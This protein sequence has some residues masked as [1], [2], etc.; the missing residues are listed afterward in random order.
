MVRRLISLQFYVKLFCP[1]FDQ[2]V[3]IDIRRQTL[4]ASH[5]IYIQHTRHMHNLDMSLSFLFS[6]G[7]S[8][9]KCIMFLHPSV[10]MCLYIGYF[11]HFGI[12]CVCQCIMCSVCVC[13]LSRFF[14]SQSLAPGLQGSTGDCE[15]LRGISVDQNRSVGIIWDHWPSL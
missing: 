1:E 2:S 4:I 12:L 13:L 15:G 6:L 8:C 11:G 10:G 5:N 3:R 9:L 7:P 14:N